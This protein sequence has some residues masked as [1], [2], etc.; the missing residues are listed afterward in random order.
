MPSRRPPANTAALKSAAPTRAARGGVN[1]TTRASLL[2]AAIKL[3][4]AKG[5]ASVSVLEIAN[6]VGAFPNHITYHF[7]GKEPLF[8]EAASRAMLRAAKHA[9]DITRDSETAEVHTRRLIGDLLGPGAPAVMLFADAMLFARQRPEL[10][11]IVR[12]TLTRLNEAGESAMEDT[13]RR[14]GWD[15]VASPR[16]ITRSFWAAIFGLALEKAAMGDVFEQE[17]AEAVAYIMIALNR[18][19]KLATLASSPGGDGRRSRQKL[20]RR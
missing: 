11:E 20:G 19:S 7:G 16:I 4:L 8:V 1:G 2:E 18:D 15:N 13:L 12:G 10:Q 5:Y 14:T 9:E 17:S 6:K 3:F